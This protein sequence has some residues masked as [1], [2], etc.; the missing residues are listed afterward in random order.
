MTQDPDGSFRYIGHICDHFSKYHVL[1]PLRTKEP[2][3][4]ASN[5]KRFYFSNFGLPKIVQF[6]NGAEFVDLIIKATIV[7]WPGRAK[8]INGSPRHSQSQGFNLQLFLIF[9]PININTYY[10][11][12]NTEGSKNLT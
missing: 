11:T 8:I 10:Y 1:F 12:Q 5:L 4:V 6:D 7:Q 2:I 3:E 9:L